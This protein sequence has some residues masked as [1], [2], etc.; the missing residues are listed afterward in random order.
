MKSQ[1]GCI[2]IALLINMV[3]FMHRFIVHCVH[4]DVYLH[5]YL[6]VCIISFEYVL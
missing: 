5:T 3:D 1:R 6:F 2:G 4:C